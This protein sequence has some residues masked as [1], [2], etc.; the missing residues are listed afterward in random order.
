[1]EHNKI[2][3]VSGL[4]LVEMNILGEMGIEICENKNI[5]KYVKTIFI[6]VNDKN[7]K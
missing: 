4:A 3:N 6:Y 5:K 1:M 2:S 7:T